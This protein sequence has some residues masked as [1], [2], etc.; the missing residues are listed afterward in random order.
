[1]KKIVPIFF[2]GLVFLSQAT[3]RADVF[4]NNGGGDRN[5]ANAANWAGG[6]TGLLPS[7]A[8]AGSAIIKP[9]DIPANFPVVSTAGNFAN[10]IYLD[11]N[12]ALQIAS[13]GVLTA[14]SLITGQWGNSGVVDVAGGQLNLG[15][16]YLGNGGFDGKVNISAGLVAADY[17]SINTNGGAA[18]NIGSAGSFML[19]VSNLD[20]VNYWITNNAIRAENGASGW[21]VNLDT[22]TQ[23]GKIILTAV[24]ATA[25][26]EPSTLGTFGLGLVLLAGTRAMRRR[27]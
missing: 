21:S 8:G 19:A 26:P 11:T 14:T 6:G 7:A 9:W 20:N 15:S 17:L 2:S 16:L 13:Q 22:T 5:W 24:S 1:M 4:W 27:A 12:S 18:L 25:I 23:S 10:S 3:L